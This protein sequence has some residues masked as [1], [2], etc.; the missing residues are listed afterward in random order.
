L[1]EHYLRPVFESWGSYLDNLKEAGLVRDIPSPFALFAF[2]GAAQQF[3]NLAPLVK[4]LYEIDARDPKVAHD[5]TNTLIEIFL[6]G[7]TR[8]SH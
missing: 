8:R 1:V 5:Y 4:E 7:A 3:F 2:F 6:T